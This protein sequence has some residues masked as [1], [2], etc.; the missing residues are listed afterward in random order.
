MAQTLSLNDLER[1]VQ[2][3]LLEMASAKEDAR[4]D[5]NG[6]GS[7]KTA[8]DTA[9]ITQCEPDIPSEES[10][11][12]RKGVM[13]CF[14][15]SHKLAPIWDFALEHFRDKEH[16]NGPVAAFLEALCAGNVTS[17]LCD[18]ERGVFAYPSVCGTLLL[19]TQKST[20]TI[21]S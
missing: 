9:G 16:Y 12:V 15:V 1:E 18:I 8:G 5:G 19:S 17:K 20:H 11:E 2:I 7:C 14:Q 13:M 21:R 6:N 4:A 3:A 10:D